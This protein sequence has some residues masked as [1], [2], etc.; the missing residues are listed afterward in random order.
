[1]LVNQ[2]K[3]SYYKF[4]YDQTQLLRDLEDT[5]KC[6]PEFSAEI[7]QLIDFE[8]KDNCCNCFSFVVY[9]NP[10]SIIYWVETYLLSILLSCIN[11]QYILP[12]YLCR[13]YIDS[14][15]LE[16]MDTLKKTK[17]NDPFYR[18][19][20]VDDE[21]MAAINQLLE[22]YNELLNM[23]NV[24]IY[25][26]ICGDISFEIEDSEH[27]SINKTRAYRFNALLDPTV[28]INISREADGIVTFTD[29]HNIKC[30]ENSNK[31]LYL[32]YGNA[33]MD[34]NDKFIKRK[35]ELLNPKCNPDYK[36]WIPYSG[37][38]M[39]YTQ[40]INPEYFIDKGLFSDIYAGAVGFNF[41]LNK[42]HYQSRKQ[43]LVDKINELVQL[44][45]VRYK[46]PEYR[47]RYQTQIKVGFDEILLFD[48]CKCITAFNY[49]NY[50]I[51]NETQLITQSEYF[52]KL[53]LLNMTT[54]N[55]FIYQFQLVETAEKV[56]PQFKKYFNLTPDQEEKII[57]TTN[58]FLIQYR[59]FIKYK[60]SYGPDYKHHL[61]QLILFEYILIK[62]LNVT[63]QF[64]IMI[65]LKYDIKPDKFLKPV[66]YLLSNFMLN[67][68]HNYHIK[69]LYRF[70][71]QN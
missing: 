65:H 59:E 19:T 25:T 39:Y 71:D 36:Y 60:E 11:I 53:S 52:Y 64:E 22:I 1:V 20:V 26:I 70:F 18:S 35:N 13:V 44:S 8:P 69:K 28:N 3:E 37:W 5:T 32:N 21:I 68:S 67:M 30:F 9:T 57:D 17:L 40:D 33:A 6:S 12:D 38:L 2:K 58:K 4:K 45:S 31:L 14:S 7:K 34:I 61:A 29:C 56:V 15:V 23:D 54:I 16:R 55:S 51:P 10:D 27:T 46:N 50:E 66:N 47:H 42:D 62:I 48:L 63:K 24:E 49:I 41:K 43:F